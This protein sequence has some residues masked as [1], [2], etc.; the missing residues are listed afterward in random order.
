MLAESKYK[1]GDGIWKTKEKV[2]GDILQYLDTE[3]YP[4]DVD[5]DFNEA[6][7]SDLVLYIV[8]PI[9]SSFK[10]KTGR[11]VFLR[12]EKETISTKEEFVVVDLVSVAEEKF[13]LIV[14]VKGSSLGLLERQCLLAIKDMGDNNGGGEVY[15][16]ITTG[17]SWRMFKYDGVS[18]WKT[19]RMDAVFD[20]MDEDKEK[21]MKDYSILVDCIYV[22]LSRGGIAKKDV[23]VSGD[24]FSFGG[25]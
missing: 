5:S 14:K 18:F 7:V 25:S 2:Y 21:W 22:A 15:G 17:E 13:V 23:V 11:D 9:L 24:C 10:R 16:F 12:R 6:N 1:P 8:G 3:G 19:E 4:I 20:T